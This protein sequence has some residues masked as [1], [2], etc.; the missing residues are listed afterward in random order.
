M[1]YAKLVAAIVGM[2]VLALKQFMGVELGDGATDK[3][4]DVIIMV[5]TAVGVWGVKNQ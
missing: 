5:L 4:S 3:I 2:G 1:G